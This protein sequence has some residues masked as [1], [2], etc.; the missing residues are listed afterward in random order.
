MPPLSA[1]PP[2]FTLLGHRKGRLVGGLQLP[3]T[4]RT[5]GV[6]LVPNLTLSPLRFQGALGLQAPPGP[7]LQ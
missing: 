5:G 3:N 1:Q 2:P 6:G 4:G 7:R